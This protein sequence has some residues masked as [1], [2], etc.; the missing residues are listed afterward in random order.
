MWKSLNNWA[1]FIKGTLSKQEF[2]DKHSFILV[3]NKEG[4]N[5]FIKALEKFKSDKKVTTVCD[6]IERLGKPTSSSTIKDY[7]KNILSLG[8][9]ALGSFLNKLTIETDEDG[10]IEK[11]KNRLFEI[12]RKS[13]VLEV[14]YDSLLWINSSVSRCEDLHFLSKE[15]T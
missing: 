11:I 3:T 4:N 9:R 1:L 14:I 12:Y 7:I 2:L 15:S 10:I 6:L 5:D 13:E 8:K